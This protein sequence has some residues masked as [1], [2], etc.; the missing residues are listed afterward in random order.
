MV[1][2]AKCF[3]PGVTQA[4]VERATARAAQEAKK[5]SHAGNP[6]A[7][8]GSIV[9]VDD[10][11]LLC[12]FEASSRTAVWR[13]N[14]RAGIPCERVMETVIGLPGAGLGDPIERSRK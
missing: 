12:L 14:E 1:F 2:A 7:Y 10:D 8:L 6:V 13:T 3:W 5:A 4:E 9:F 11:L